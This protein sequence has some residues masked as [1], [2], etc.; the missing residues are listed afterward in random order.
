MSVYSCISKDRTDFQL[1]CGPS[2]THERNIEIQSVWPS[3]DIPFP[4]PPQSPGEAC[5]IPLCP[6]QTHDT[7]LPT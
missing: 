6:T 3:T 1:V 4:P 5:V 7:M 2:A